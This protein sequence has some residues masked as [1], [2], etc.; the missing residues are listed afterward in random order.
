MDGLLMETKLH[1]E[2]R[3]QGEQYE[4]WVCDQWPLVY[5]KTLTRVIGKDNQYKY[6][7][8][9]EGVEIKN[10][11]RMNNDRPTGN[12]YIETH[13]KANKNNARYVE[14]G[15]RHPACRWYLVG[16]RREW[17]IFQK[18]ILQTVDNTNPE[19]VTRIQT[20][21]S[22][23]FVMAKTWATGLMSKHHVFEAG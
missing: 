6:G 13:E 14:S 18:T 8:T 9:Y 22:M 19:W 1:R 4:Q 17:F 23:G 20:P 2:L 12:V 11:E 15:I 3:A 16:D 5:G 10:D 7:D 21:T